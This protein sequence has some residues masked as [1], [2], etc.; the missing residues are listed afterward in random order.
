[1][2][3][4]P[5]VIADAG[6]LIALARIAA[7]DLLKHLFGQVAI[8]AMVRD[9][10]LPPGDFPGSAALQFALDAGWLCCRD[11]VPGAWRPLNPGVDAGEAS[12]IALA[13]Q[14]PDALLLMDDRTGRAE[15]KRQGITFLRT[16]AVI[17]MAKLQG[18]IPAARPILE[19]FMS[20]GYF[21]SQEVIE[22]V[23]ADI[24]E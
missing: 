2:A 1:M 20:V 5:V 23:L 14:E 10:I 7:L 19:Q 24:G 11:V 13:L 22:A 18:L 6:P 21:I 9:E 4:T 17:S 15:A 16:A 3:A 8:T 12:T